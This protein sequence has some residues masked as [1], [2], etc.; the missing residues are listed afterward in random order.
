[1]TGPLTGALTGPLTGPVTGPLTGPL[2]GPVT[3]PV[4]AG[5]APDRQHREQPGWHV[6]FWHVDHLVKWTHFLW[7]RFLHH[8]PGKSPRL[9]SRSM[10]SVRRKRR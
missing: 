4:T 8:C 1:V 3:G 9:G 2:T 10:L 6:V 7:D 5:A